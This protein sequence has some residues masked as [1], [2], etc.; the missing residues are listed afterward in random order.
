MWIKV[1]VQASRRVHVY[2]V[3]V[4]KLYGFYVEAKLGVGVEKNAEDEDKK[5]KDA[6]DVRDQVKETIGFAMMIQCYWRDHVL[7]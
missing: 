2:L 7:S 5:L 1:F 3:E 6:C 4:K